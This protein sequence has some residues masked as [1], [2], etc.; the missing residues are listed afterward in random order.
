MR[1]HARSTS[2]RIAKL[3]PLFVIAALLLS[4]CGG[5]NNTAGGAKKTFTLFMLPKFI[6][7]APFDLAHKGAAA[8][9]A[10][11]GDKVNYGGP[12]KADP[13]EQVQFINNVIAQKPDA[14]I[15]SADD[16][17][18]VV[19]ALKSA[20]DKG[21]KTV[22]FD[23]DTNPSARVVYASPPSAQA[24]GKAQVEILGSQIGY[25]GKFA[26]LSATATATNQNTW[27]GFMKDA[28]KDPKYAGMTLVKVAYG[29]DDDTKSAQEMQGLLQAYPDLKGVIAPTTVGIAA[30]ARVVSQA[31]KCNVVVTGLGLPNQMR[32]FVNS[33]CVK[34][35]A[36]WSF[37]DLGYL[38]AC[39]AHHVLAGDIT[40]KSGDTFD[41]G[42]LGK[43]TIGDNGTV[44]VGD[45]LVF[46]KDNIA[47]YQF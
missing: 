6:G 26:V 37:E 9:A 43:K 14:I 7:I 1:E 17:D 36:L 2:R 38:S 15:I 46:T 34:Q 33:G 5:S 29:N 30:A 41:C 20:S 47:Q 13:Q 24:I 28:L 19:P 40:G 18:A 44:T 27:I 39:A 21:I 45:P 42:K 3:A 4:A 23:S 11:V 12:T 22:S 31:N 16:P 35:F 10:S 8:Y 25:Q 32:E